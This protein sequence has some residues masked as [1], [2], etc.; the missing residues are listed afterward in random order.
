MSTKIIKY[1]QESLCGE[2]GANLHLIK[3]KRVGFTFT[4]FETTIAVD[5]THHTQVQ[6]IQIVSEVAL[7]A[8]F[9]SKILRKERECVIRTMIH[10]EL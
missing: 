9:C 5:E 4:K 8:N 7:S 3:F 2:L 10:A 1:M 6:E